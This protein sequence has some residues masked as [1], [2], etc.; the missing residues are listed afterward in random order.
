MT[1]IIKVDTIQNN[2]GTTGLTIDS[3]G[4]ITSGKVPAWR[5][6]RDTDFNVTNSATWTQI[7]WDALDIS[8]ENIFMQNVTYSSGNIT[9]PVAGIYQINATVR[10]DG[11]T[12]DSGY[13]ILSLQRNGDRA[14]LADTYSLNT[15][16][17]STYQSFSTSTVFKCDANDA[18]SVYGYSSNDSSWHISNSVSTFSGVRIG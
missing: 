3:N 4:Y 12:T 9:V 2:G 7:Q 14:G 6:G 8:A 15:R 10:A 16:Y 18:L 5:I 1:G 17:S 13:F 11:L